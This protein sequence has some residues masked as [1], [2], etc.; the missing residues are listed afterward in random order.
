M[1]DLCNLAVAGTLPVLHLLPLQSQGRGLGWAVFSL[2]AIVR[3]EAL[4]N[5]WH[6]RA[7]S[8]CGSESL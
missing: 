8:C 3:V 1:I 7:I 6:I 4:P 5:I 2:N